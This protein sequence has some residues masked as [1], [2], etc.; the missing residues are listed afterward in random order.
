MQVF[1]ECLQMARVATI[2]NELLRL[3][4]ITLNDLEAE[5]EIQKLL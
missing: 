3:E 5:L 2:S 1:F 4:F